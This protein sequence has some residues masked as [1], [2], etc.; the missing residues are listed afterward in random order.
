MINPIERIYDD[1]KNNGGR[2]GTHNVP[3]PIFDEEKDYSKVR[4]CECGSLNVSR[5][6]STNKV[7]CRKCGNEV[8]SRI[9]FQR[10]I[11]KIHEKE[12]KHIEEALK[13]GDTFSA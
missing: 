6:L 5:D 7:V 12:S 11:E 13:R 8:S 10:E 3:T 2:N 4:Q 9:D 1:Y